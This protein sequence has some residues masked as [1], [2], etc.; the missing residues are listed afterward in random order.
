MDCDIYKASFFSHRLKLRDSSCSGVSLAAVSIAGMGTFG[1]GT[2]QQTQW[3]IYVI[4]VGVALLTG[5]R[6]RCSRRNTKKLTIGE[7]VALASIDGR[8]GFFIAPSATSY[9]HK[10]TRDSEPDGLSNHGA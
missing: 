6:L 10:N 4:F 7:E 2:Y 1:N 5:K 9:G 8:S 3:Q